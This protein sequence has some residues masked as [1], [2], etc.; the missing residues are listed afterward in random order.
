MQVTVHNNTPADNDGISNRSTRNNNNNDNN[1]N[2]NNNNNR[3]NNRH[4]NGDGDEDEDDDA[5]GN[6][7][8]DEAPVRVGVMSLEVCG[9]KLISGGDDCVIRVWN[10]NNWTCE[11]ILK[12]HQGEVW[13][14]T[15]NVEGLLISGSVDGT[16]RVWRQEAH[17]TSAVAAAAAAAS[18]GS[19]SGGLSV[20][21]DSIPRTGSSNALQSYVTSRGAIQNI[22]SESDDSAGAL[23]TSSHGAHAPPVSWVCEHTIQSDGA[24]Y[25]LCCLDGRIVS[26][27][28]GNKI[29]VWKTGRDRSEDWSLH[30]WFETEEAGVWSLTVC[31]GKLVSGGVDGT[32]RVWI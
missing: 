24:V 14:L 5:D 21:S 12:A 4:N 19:S 31:K 20:G 25:S 15:V 23:G 2:N 8:D 28:A 1:N 6:D 18:S 29:S 16:I 22:H 11:Q 27:G 10:T 7:D 9:E 26:A 17:D 30:K 13:S 32:V 3:N